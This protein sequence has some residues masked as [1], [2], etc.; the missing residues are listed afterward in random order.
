[1]LVRALILR[2]PNLKRGLRAQVRST[3]NSC[4]K[5]NYTNTKQKWL[6]QKVLATAATIT[7]TTATASTTMTTTTSFR[8]RIQLQILLVVTFEL[9]FRRFRRRRCRRRRRQFPPLGVAVVIF[10]VVW[11]PAKK[12]FFCRVRN[13]LRWKKS[14][15]D[16]FYRRWWFLQTL[17]KW[18]DVDVG[19]WRRRQRRRRHCCRTNWQKIEQ[20]K[21]RNSSQSLFV[22]SQ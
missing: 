8:N 20:Y 1:M 13:E 16:F 10:G 12:V 9:L 15:N 19:G 18:I 21:I 2:S 22:L 6:A 4:C 17:R 14:K 7:T 3:S 11:P 5:K